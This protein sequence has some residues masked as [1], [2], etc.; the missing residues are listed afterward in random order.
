MHPGTAPAAHGRD[1]DVRLRL[2]ESARAGRGGPDPRPRV[3]R[4]LS[5]DPREPT[6]EREA[7]VAV[8]RDADEER[9]GPGEAEHAG[10]RVLSRAC[11]ERSRDAAEASTDGGDV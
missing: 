1:A 2:A 9:E 3:P 5:R 7:D 10:P 8:Q 11:G 4:N 6:E